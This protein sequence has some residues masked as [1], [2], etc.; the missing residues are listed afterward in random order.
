[1]NIIIYELVLYYIY[2]S[3]IYAIAKT[4][5]KSDEP[6]YK[7]KKLLYALKEKLNYNHAPEA[8][9]YYDVLN[10]LLK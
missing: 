8:Y 5:R 9:T 7:S 10:A 3:N 6:L 1:M 4:L 2:N